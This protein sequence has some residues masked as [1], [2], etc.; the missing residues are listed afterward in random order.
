M[1]LDTCSVMRTKYEHMAVIL[2]IASARLGVEDAGLRASHGCLR[3]GNEG[4]SAAR[5]TAIVFALGRVHEVTGDSA[6]MFAVL[7]AAQMQGPVFWIGEARHIGSLAPMALQPYLDPARV[8]VTEGVGAK[9]VLWATEQALRSARGGC[10]VTEVDVGPNLRESRRLQIAAEESGA[11][12]L[13]LVHGTP[14]TS[15]CETRWQ[16]R[17]HPDGD[18]CWVWA[19]TKNRKGNLKRWQV[20][21]EAQGKGKANGTCTL[22]F[23]AATAA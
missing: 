15:A 2:N 12:G 4:G 19:Q 18:H 17:A 8:T 21:C 7:V 14:Q 3:L 20:R 23:S 11:L 6:D 13:V 22:H 9:E 16:C 5:A 1:P 10:V